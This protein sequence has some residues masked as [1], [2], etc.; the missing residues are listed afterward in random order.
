VDVESLGEVSRREVATYARTR[1]C[2]ILVIRVVSAT[3]A[4]CPLS[5]QTRK[6]CL[7]VEPPR[8]RTR[9]D[10]FSYGVHWLGR[11][12]GPIYQVIRIAHVV[13]L[14]PQASRERG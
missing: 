5:G 7:A 2:P 13:R 6:R 11:D 3:A 12:M 14:K 10:Q 9:C 1:L 8:N 4:V